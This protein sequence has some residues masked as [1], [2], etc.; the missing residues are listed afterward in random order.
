[1]LKVIID[2][3][4]DVMSFDEEWGG[5][6]NNRFPLICE[7][8]RGLASTYAGTARVESDSSKL[9]VENKAYR[10]YLMNLSLY[11]IMHTNQFMELQAL[12]TC[13]I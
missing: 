5:V 12:A 2:F 10:T 3:Q 8:S 4:T 1:M 6:L 13:L 7:F 11:G 9:G